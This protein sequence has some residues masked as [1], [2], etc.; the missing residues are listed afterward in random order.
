MQRG[1]PPVLIQQS[2]VDG[3]TVLALDGRLD[4]DSA[5]DLHRALLA[6]LDAQPDALVCDLHGLLGIDDAQGLVFSAADHPAARWP[7]TTV[8]LCR[9][10]P[11]VARVLRRL[12]VPNY[13]SLHPTV[14]AAVQYARSRSPCKVERLTMAPTTAAAGTARAFTDEVCAR[15]GLGRLT[16]TALLVVSELVTIAALHGYTDVDLQLEA[17][18]GQLLV[19]VHDGNPSFFPIGDEGPA[20]G[21]RL[22]VI[23]RASQAWG[24]RPHADGGKVVWC[25]LGIRAG[26]IQAEG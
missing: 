11:D 21:L 10:R 26:G 23:M 24:V 6:A 1:F 2:A 22:Q 13:L 5:A 15:W 8:S 25:E 19:A 4:M 14:E 18:D 16:D 12:R 3:C 20:A 17:R 7:G 9:A